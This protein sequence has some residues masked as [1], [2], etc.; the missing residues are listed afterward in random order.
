M[1]KYKKLAA[2]GTVILV[3]IVLSG[4]SLYQS[5]SGGTGQSQTTTSSTQSSQI[6][7]ATEGAAVI[8]YTGSGFS[9]LEIFVKVGQTVEF[10]ND[11]P[12]TVQV[13]SVPHPTHTSFPELNLNSIAAG[14]SKSTTFTKAGTYKYHNHLNPGQNGQIVVE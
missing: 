2:I 9:P 7:P 8:S 12:A 13:N 11:S 3:S 10:K 14:Q 6:Q 1:T 5:K 4:C